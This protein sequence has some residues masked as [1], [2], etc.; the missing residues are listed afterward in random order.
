MN[1]ISYFSSKDMIYDSFIIRTFS[2]S[3]CS[4]QLFNYFSQLPIHACPSAC[5]CLP[6]LLALSL[7]PENPRS[8]L[9]LLTWTLPKAVGLS[10]NIA[11][12]EGRAGRA[13]HIS[14]GFLPLK[15]ELCLDHRTCGETTA[16][17]ASIHGQMEGEAPSEDVHR[18]SCHS[19]K[20]LHR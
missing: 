4:C 13:A 17:T 5:I 10:W 14:Y 16:T 18:Q 8:H 19:G 3:H 7:T 6:F 2:W 11:Q 1:L 12:S 20:E 15:G 9:S